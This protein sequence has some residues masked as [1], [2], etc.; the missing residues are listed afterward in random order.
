METFFQE[1]NQSIKDIATHIPQNDFSWPTNITLS[2]VV[3]VL[4]M[5]YWNQLICLHRSL[6]S[7]F[8]V[9]L[10]TLME[11]VQFAEANI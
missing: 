8:S 1:M 2:Q 10:K 5:K 3:M 6:Y 11:H 9:K 4:L 7:I